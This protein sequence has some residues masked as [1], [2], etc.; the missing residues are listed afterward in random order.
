MNPHPLY[1]S[2]AV[3]EQL[4]RLH[5]VSNLYYTQEQ[6]RLGEWLV[7]NSVADK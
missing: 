4:G 5:H 7:K 3:T 1:L 2:R 6:G